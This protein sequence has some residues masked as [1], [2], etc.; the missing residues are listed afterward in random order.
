MSEIFGLSNEENKN[1]VKTWI[2]DMMTPLKYKNGIIHRLE[3]FVFGNSHLRVT[4]T[5]KV[6]H[7][8]HEIEL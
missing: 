8:C 5:P 1:I 7:R 4:T 2:E 3:L 6:L